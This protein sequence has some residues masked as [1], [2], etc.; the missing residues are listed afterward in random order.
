MLLD[1]HT[2]GEQTIPHFKGGEGETI[3]RMFTDENGKIMLGRLAPGASIGLHTHET[4]SEIIYIL[5]GTGKALYD[6]GSEALAP[7][8]CHYCP[9]GHSHSL[10]NDG[11]EELRFFAVVPEQ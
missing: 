2:I 5:S 3:A 4:S 6:G 11:A 9:K 8:Q 10:I 1:F 7:G